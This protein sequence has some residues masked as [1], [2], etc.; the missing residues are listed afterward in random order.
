MVFAFGG[1]E[2][3][4]MISHTESG[5]FWE[6]VAT[7]AGAAC[8]TRNRALCIRQERGAVGAEKRC[9]TSVER[10]ASVPITEEQTIYSAFRRL[11]SPN[12]G[13]VCPPSKG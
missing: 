3:I 9:E 5:S 4:F 8:G 1:R 2:S 11:S 7:E 6:K 12:S 13:V 10:P